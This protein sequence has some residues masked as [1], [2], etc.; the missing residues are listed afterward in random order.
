MQT[1]LGSTGI[2][3]TRI[4]RELAAVNTPVRLVSRNP[5]AVSGGEE[6]VQADLTNAQQTFEAVKGS[7]VVYLT[8]G[9]AYDT[10]IWQQQWPVI[11]E[12][13][14]NACVDAGAAL[15]FFDNVYMYGK[16]NGIMTEDLPF[17]PCSLK[18]EVRARIARSMLE[19]MERGNLKGLIARAADFYGP[20]A[21]TS[22]VDILVFSQLAKG[23]RTQWMGG[24]HFRH[25]FTY[26]E[27]AAKAC[28][29]LAQDEKAWNQTWHLPT[30]AAALTG[31]EFVQLAATAFAAPDDMQVLRKWMLQLA[32][33][34]NPMVKE[35][36]EMMYQFEQDYLFSSEKFE[37]AY[38]FEP[39]TYRRGIVETA[40]SYTQ[41]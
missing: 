15:L 32:G 28:V 36:V 37:K 29:M 31:K 14:I 19:E 25:S 18:G 9:L 4:A 38:G 30:H 22:V 16:V 8:A 1:V 17:N 13:V 34:F 5:V 6:L 3:G 21:H 7:K 12:N 23:K 35:S 40:L 10:Q 11:M 20:G 33:L 2:I 41:N 39:V 27:D 26:V 24:D